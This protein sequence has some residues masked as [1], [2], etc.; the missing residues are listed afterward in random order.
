MGR[1]KAREMRP[2]IDHAICRISHAQKRKIYFRLPERVKRHSPVSCTP[3]PSFQGT[4]F[5]D[6][7]FAHPGGVK[8]PLLQEQHLPP[9]EVRNWSGLILSQLVLVLFPYWPPRFLEEHV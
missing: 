4:L 9:S 6:V 8:H 5:W 2:K 3:T 1:A 7:G